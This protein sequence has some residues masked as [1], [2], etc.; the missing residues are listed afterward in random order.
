M[1]KWIITIF[2]FLF[3]SCNR[4][5]QQRH[6][7]DEA[8]KQDTLTEIDTFDHLDWVFYYNINPES[9]VLLGEEKVTDC[10]KKEYLV[11]EQ[12]PE[13]VRFILIQLNNCGES[14][15]MGVME[16][17]IP[18]EKAALVNKMS[19][20]VNLNYKVWEEVVA[21]LDSGSFWT[22]EDSMNT[23]ITGDILTL[24]AK[25]EGKTNKISVSRTSESPVLE[26]IS[27]IRAV[28]TGY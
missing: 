27:Q 3:L 21:V 17:E 20:S 16:N 26:L 12:R 11:F 10:I 2:L 14:L 25:V 15:G 18:G 7:S 24:I 22:M 28:E 19:Y 23:E 13:N 1:I 8:I 5:E 6:S 4:N 9:F